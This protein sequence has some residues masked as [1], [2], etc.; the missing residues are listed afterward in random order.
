MLYLQANYNGTFA[1]AAKN[2]YK[3]ELFPYDY[4]TILDNLPK[5]MTFAQLNA[6]VVKKFGC[7]KL[8]IQ[9]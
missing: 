6:L 7:K 5:D 3:D 2:E 9:L 8:I 4:Y 1:I